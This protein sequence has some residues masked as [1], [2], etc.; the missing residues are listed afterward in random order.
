MGMGKSKR[1]LRG[2]LLLAPGEQGLSAF[3]SLGEDQLIIE[4]AD[5][6]QEAWDRELIVA[7]PYDTL[8]TQLELGDVTLYFQADE[9]LKFAQQLAEYVSMPLKKRR[10]ARKH[11]TG[12][13]PQTGTDQQPETEQ[14]PVASLSVPVQKQ[15]TPSRRR[16]KREHE[17]TWTTRSVGGGMDGRVCR[18]C[19][20]VSIDL[21]DTFEMTGDPTPLLTLRR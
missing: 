11:Q 15:Q 2:T 16:A 5:G 6:G 20:R 3:V 19:G 7:D 14:Q 18:G 13:E 1:G 17:H 4:T 12:T 8:T 21:T 10:K 9:P